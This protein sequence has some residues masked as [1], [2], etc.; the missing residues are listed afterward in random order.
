[1]NDDFCMAGEK[2]NVPDVPEQLRGA[3]GL[4]LGNRIEE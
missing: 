4:H 2:H 3:D 1:M